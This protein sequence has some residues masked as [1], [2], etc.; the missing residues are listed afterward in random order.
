MQIELKKIKATK[1]IMDQ[2]QQI[3]QSDI[4]A[5]AIGEGTVLGW[6]I[7]KSGKTLLRYILIKTSEGIYRKLRFPTEAEKYEKYE[8]LDSNT[9]VLYYFC[10]VG[11]GNNI[12]ENRISFGTK[13]FE[14]DHFY[15]KIQAVRRLAQE[16][17][18]F[19]I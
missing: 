19:F 11:Y 3:S 12:I 14:R 1:S 8:Q 17:G 9:R 4:S 16:Q 6:F 2:I 15:N 5:L 7:L 18:Q 13:E 10:K